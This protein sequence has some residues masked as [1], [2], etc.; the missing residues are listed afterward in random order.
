[1]AAPNFARLLV[2]GDEGSS[3]TRESFDGEVSSCSTKFE[4]VVHPAERKRWKNSK[5]RLK[6]EI[7][8]MELFDALSGK[9]GRDFDSKISQKV[10]VVA[11]DTACENL[12]VNDRML[13]EEMWKKLDIVFHVAALTN[14]YERYD[15]AFNTNTMG[16]VHVIDFAKKCEKIQL[17][18]HVSTAYVSGEKTGLIPEKP[19]QMGEALKGSSKL[20]MDAEKRLISE[21]LEDLISR[22]VSDDSIKKTMR[23]LGHQRMT[24]PV[25]VAYGKGK[26]NY[27]FCK[28]SSFI[29]VIP[30]DMVVNSMI[31]SAVAHANIL[32]WLYTN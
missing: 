2:D 12:G 4:E 9:W 28:G 26:L 30:A 5:S 8:D 3:L 10:I 21:T 14:F 32:V 31:E 19:L 20:D 11:G 18:L 24:D 15:V 1:M 17:V 23:E 29:D 16:V 25:L 22:Q 27:F 13:R 7:I 6:N